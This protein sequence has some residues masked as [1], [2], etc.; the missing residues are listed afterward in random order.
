[1]AEEHVHGTKIKIKCFC[2]RKNTHVT[3]GCEN[4]SISS[5]IWNLG[6]EKREK[7][8]KKHIPV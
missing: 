7:V 1:V 2:G 4:D 5:K 6:G 8:L 3:E